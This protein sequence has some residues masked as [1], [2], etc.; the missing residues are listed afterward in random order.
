MSPRRHARFQLTKD[1]AKSRVPCPPEYG[2]NGSGE[3]VYQRP[4][5][6]YGNPEHGEMER[7][8]L[9]AGLGYLDVPACI[10]CLRPME[11]EVERGLRGEHSWDAAVRIV[12][13]IEPP[14]GWC[15]CHDLEDCGPCDVADAAEDAVE[16][17]PTPLATA[18]APVK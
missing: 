3:V 5:H 11:G 8:S 17:E 12:G 7:C 13:K 6:E 9:C 4:G 1:G 16:V 18:P 10:R 2:C 14:E 15:G